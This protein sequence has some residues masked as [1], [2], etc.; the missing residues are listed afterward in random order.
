MPQLRCGVIGLGMMGEPMAGRIAESPHPCI[1]FDIR[2]EPIDRVVARGAAAA[3]SVAELARSSD[4]VMI[5]VVSESQVSNVMIGEDHD[6]CVLTNARPGTI[7]VIHSTIPPGACAE[8]GARAAAF[9]VRVL[10]APITGGP[11]RAATGSLTIMVGGDSDTFTQCR[12]I[13]DLLGKFVVHVGDLGHGQVAKVAN[14][15]A[16]AACVQGV[17]EALEL[18]RHAGIPEDVIL[19]VL[20]S[21]GA[22]SWAVDNWPGISATFDTYSRLMAKDLGIAASLAEAGG[23]DLPTARVI[24]RAVA[25]RSG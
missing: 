13:L 21:G 24:A 6:S 8:L 4:I 19:P 7:V 5:S 25:A 3:R 18:A 17:S 15:V 9:G 14:N 2:S 10:D 1:V 12:P 20:A 16:L 22:Q 11:A 23:F